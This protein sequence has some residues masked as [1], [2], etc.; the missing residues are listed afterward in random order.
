VGFRGAI[1]GVSPHCFRDHAA[2]CPGE[3]GLIFNI[4]SVAAH[5]TTT[6]D[7]PPRKLKAMS[8][9]V[10]GRW[11]AIGR[12]VFLRT[13]DFDFAMV[14]RRRGA[15]RCRSGWQRSQSVWADFSKALPRL[16]P[17]AISR[18]IASCSVPREVLEPVRRQRRVHSGAGDRAGASLT[19]FPAMLHGA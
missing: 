1:E 18:D 7:C 19:R 11:T 12:F 9:R 14:A 17:A 16:M 2:A 4:L 15:Y 8:G 10:F 3:N 13:T 5:T 6:N